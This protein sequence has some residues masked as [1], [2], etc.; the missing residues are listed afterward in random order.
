MSH[1]L[2]LLRLIRVANSHDSD[3]EIVEN[4][5]CDFVVNGGMSIYYI[6][7]MR[8]TDIDWD[9]LIHHKEELHEETNV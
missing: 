1:W 6:S 7:G 9:S 5:P 4:P 8:L 2:L 3:A